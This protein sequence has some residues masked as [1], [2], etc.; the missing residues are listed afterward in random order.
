MTR[1]QPKKGMR[2]TCRDGCGGHGE[3]GL[4]AQ[5]RHDPPAGSST[6]ARHLL[7]T[8]EHLSPA[9]SPGQ[10]STRRLGLRS[11]ALPRGASLMKTQKL[12]QR[13]QR[14]HLPL[15]TTLRR[16]ECLFTSRVRRTGHLK[17]SQE[18]GEL[19]R[20]RGGRGESVNPFRSAGLTVLQ[21]LVGRENCIYQNHSMGLVGTAFST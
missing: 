6:S 11:S 7:L 3:A 12:D 17:P 9:S 14:N 15:S 19:Q 10:G 18:T 20:G 2:T 21:P 8:C 16:E 4:G 13:L 5:W 1:H